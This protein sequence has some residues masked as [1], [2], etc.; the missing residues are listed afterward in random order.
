MESRMT[1]RAAPLLLVSICTRA[2]SLLSTTVRARQITP[3][4]VASGGVVGGVV[5][6]MAATAGGGEGWFS[7]NAPA[8][9]ARPSSTPPARVLSSR[10]SRVCR[11]RM[12]SEALGSFVVVLCMGFRSRRGVFEVQGCVAWSCGS[13]ESP[14]RRHDRRMRL[15]CVE[16]DAPGLV[17]LRGQ[18]SQRDMYVVLSEASEVMGPIRGREEAIRRRRGVGMRS[19]RTRRIRG[20]GTTCRPRPVDFSFRLRERRFAAPRCSRRSQPMKIPHGPR[21]SIIGGKLFSDRARCDRWSASRSLRLRCPKPRS[22]WNGCVVI[23]NCRVGTCVP[24]VSAL[25]R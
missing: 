17:L 18:G 10:F 16:L 7:A 22:A 6:G 11:S 5:A 12:I 8:M 14:V 1:R 2:V 4:K 15:A 23:P 13:S 19:V 9:P 24:N 3:L 20:D 21:R 25:R